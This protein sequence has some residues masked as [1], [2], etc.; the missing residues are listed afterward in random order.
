MTPGEKAFVQLREI[1]F[2]RQLKSRSHE[3]E[4]EDEDASL[5]RELHNEEIKRVFDKDTRA[6]LDGEDRPIAPYCA[7]DFLY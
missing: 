2:N 3:R 7:N 1:W 5:R 4:W 6:I